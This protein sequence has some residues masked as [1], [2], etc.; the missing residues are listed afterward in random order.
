MK[1]DITTG[2]KSD[3]SRVKKTT[4]SSSGSCVLSTSVCCHSSDKKEPTM[5]VTNEGENDEAEGEIKKIEDYDNDVD[6]REK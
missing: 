6:S 3:V 4:S 2:S 1:S 5:K